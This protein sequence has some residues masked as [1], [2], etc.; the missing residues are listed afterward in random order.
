MF[1]P[2]ETFACDAATQRKVF[3]TKINTRLKE[4]KEIALGALVVAEHILIHTDKSCHPQPEVGI[5]MD[6]L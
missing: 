6:I 1:L 5:L 2:F 4:F 3:E